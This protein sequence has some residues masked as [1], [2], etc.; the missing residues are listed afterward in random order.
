MPAESMVGQ[1]EAIADSIGA[2]RATGFR[3]HSMWLQ[4]MRSLESTPAAILYRSTRSL[5][6]GSPFDNQRSMA[7][8]YVNRMVAMIA[9]WVASATPLPAPDVVGA[10]YR[11]TRLTND[12]TDFLILT[13][14]STRGSEVL[15]G[16]GETLDILL[17]PADAAK[18]VWRLTHFSAE[19]IT[20]QRT[21][22]G[23]HLQIVSP[24]AAEIVV[25][26]SDPSVG[27]QLSVSAQRFAR[28]AALDRWQLASELVERNNEN[29][30]TATT[31]RASDRQRQRTWLTWPSAP[32]PTPNRCT[33][34]ATPMEVCGWRAAPTPGRCAVNGSWP[35]H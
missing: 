30:I 31:T 22:T 11:C 1:I 16:D 23:A 9:P 3:W 13:S 20:P 10:P 8:S 14:I 4:T 32:W 26:S 24:D 15:A 27:G 21:S 17:T 19:R 34:P 6:S 29:W 28:Q 25:L 5:A 35:K 12:G 7:L 18:T 2:P 33:A